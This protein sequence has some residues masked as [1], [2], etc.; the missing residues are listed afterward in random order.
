MECK[1]CGYTSTVID[2]KLK[3]HYARFSS[4]E[5]PKCHAS[6]YEHTATVKGMKVSG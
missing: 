2:K 3:Q 6:S 4:D 1:K 5:C